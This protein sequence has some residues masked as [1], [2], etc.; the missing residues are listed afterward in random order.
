M[1][2]QDFC[3]PENS[4]HKRNIVAQNVKLQSHRQYA[5]WLGNNFPTGDRPN[6]RL[7]NLIFINIL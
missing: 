7:I 1:L 6:F 4:T 2:W 3:L 5:V